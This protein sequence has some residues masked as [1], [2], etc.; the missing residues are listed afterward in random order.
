MSSLSLIVNQILPHLDLSM[1]RIQ[2]KVKE[3]YGNE[4]KNV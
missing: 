1:T 4:I 2:D 3:K